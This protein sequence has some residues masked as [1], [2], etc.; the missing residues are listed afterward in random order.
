MDNPTPLE[1]L[2][3]KQL[4]TPDLE[5]DF[6]IDSGAESNIVNIP[7]WNEIRIL[8]PKLIPFKTTS[9]IATARGSNLSNYRKIQ[10]SLVPTQTM[11]Q[12]KL[13]SKLF[14]QT[15]HITDINII[16]IEFHLLINI[17]QQEIS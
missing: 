13:M 3:S 12:N 10:F 17:Y 9:R 11:E 1:S 2:K 8:H 15:V 4:L 16:S 5:I 7:T 6:L 14:I